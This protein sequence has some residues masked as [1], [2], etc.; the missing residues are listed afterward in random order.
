LLT[1]CA[2]ASPAAAEAAKAAKD[3]SE[4]TKT[5]TAA[6]TVR[7]GKS[8]PDMSCTE[9]FRPPAEKWRLPEESTEK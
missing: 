2:D 9:M 1:R 5:L 8:S 4:R 3:P 6:G 7:P